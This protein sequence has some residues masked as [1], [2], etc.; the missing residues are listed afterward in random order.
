MIEQELHVGRL[1][2]VDLERELHVRYGTG[3][4]ALPSLLPFDKDDGFRSALPILRTEAM[5][6]AATLGCGAKLR[7]GSPSRCL[8]PR[9]LIVLLPVRE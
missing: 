7:R 9:P 6:A 5:D 1:L 2:L 3:G 8:Q 4:A